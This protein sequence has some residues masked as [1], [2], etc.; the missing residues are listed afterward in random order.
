MRWIVEEGTEH[1]EAADLVV[2]AASAIESVRLAQLLDLPDSHDVVGRFVM[3]TGS[4]T[5]RVSFLNERLHTYK[6]RASSHDLDDLADPALLVLPLLPALLVCPVCE[7]GRLRW[8]PRSYRSTRPLPA[9]SPCKLRNTG[10]ICA[11]DAT[12]GRGS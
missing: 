6:G 11:P 10:I 9:S 5:P 1:R 2:L 8:E 3:F 12:F 7:A 4:L